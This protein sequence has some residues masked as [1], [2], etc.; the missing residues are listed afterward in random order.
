MWA[1]LPDIMHRKLSF[2][3]FLMICACSFG[4]RYNEGSSPIELPEFVYESNRLKAL[5][6]LAY[7]REYS[8]I[9]TYTDTVS[10][11]RE[12]LVDY[13]IPPRKKSRFK[14]WRIPRILSSRSYY[15]FI[16]DQGLD[17]VSSLYNQ[18]F[19]W[20]DWVGLPPTVELPERLRYAENASDTLFGKYSATEIWNLTN[21][22]VSVRVD[23]LADTVSKRWV[24]TMSQFFL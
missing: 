21:D 19:S 7:V 2:A 5:H 15:H 3:F 24:P 12:K 23:V 14:G 10:M 18:H 1:E 16:N 9:T 13:M 11:Y 20:S 17:S 4:Q 6:L 22:T 8:S